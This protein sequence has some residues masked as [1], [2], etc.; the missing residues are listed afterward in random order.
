MSFFR[1]HADAMRVIGATFAGH[2][3]Y[4]QESTSWMVRGTREGRPE[5]A[6]HFVVTWLPHRALVITGDLDAAVYS[7]ITHLSNIDDTMRL[8]REASMDYLSGKSTHK[9][10]FD[11]ERTARFIVEQAYAEMRD[12]FDVMGETGRDSRRMDRIVDWHLGNIHGGPGGDHGHVERKEA[13]RALI[14]DEEITPADLMEIADDWEVCRYSWPATA[15]WH[16][17]ALRT[18]ADLM[19]RAKVEQRISEARAN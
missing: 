3:I 8:V 13:C 10:E 16:Y 1:D 11:R 14:E 5:S 18:W 9:K 15:H 7:G 6:Y 19:V 12:T 2:R 17:A 4:L